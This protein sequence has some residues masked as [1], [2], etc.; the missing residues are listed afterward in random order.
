MCNQIGPQ[1]EEDIG[2]D[3][4]AHRIIGQ[5]S[6]LV[7]SLERKGLIKPEGLQTAIHRLFAR[8]K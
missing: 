8:I 5:K 4:L 6:S 3:I 1:N 7:F 2:L